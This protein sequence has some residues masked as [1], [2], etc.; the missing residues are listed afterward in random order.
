[1]QYI[2]L[3]GIAELTMRVGVT[4][5]MVQEAVENFESIGVAQRTNDHT[6]ARHHG[7]QYAEVLNLAG[8][9]ATVEVG[10]H[11]RHID[12]AGS[13][14]QRFK[15]HNQPIGQGRQGIYLL[16][17][18]DELCMLRVGVENA[19]AQIEREDGLA[20][21]WSLVANT[22]AA[23]QVHG[24]WAQRTSASGSVRQKVIGREVWCLVVDPKN[25]KNSVGPSQKAVFSS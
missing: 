3:R 17:A 18:F 23:M 11:K 5:E 21:A 8:G 9:Y 22:D 4:F 20:G 16:T 13:C 25:S 15:K 14:E 19:L 24:W 12:D 6:A 10:P 2:P 1:M 7:S